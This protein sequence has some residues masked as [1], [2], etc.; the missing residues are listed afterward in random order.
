M[1][2]FS[3]AKVPMVEIHSSSPVNLGNNTGF[4]GY[5]EIA[6]SKSNYVYAVWHN[7]GDGISFRRSTDG[8]NIFDKEINLSNNIP[9]SFQPADIYI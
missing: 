1:V 9:L 8:G 6:V 2:R 4:F 7:A 5:P 3:S